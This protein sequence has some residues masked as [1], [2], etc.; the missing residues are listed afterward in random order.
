MME[1]EYRK[2]CVA[3]SQRGGLYPGMDIPEFYAMARELFTPQEAALAA[4]LPSKPSPAAVIARETGRDEKEAADLLETMA[5]KGL[6]SSFRK[7]GVRYYMGAPFVPGIFEFQFMR[8]TRTERDRKLAQLIHAYKEA[9]ARKKG[10]VEIKFPGN[11]VIP[12]GETIRP[13]SKVHTY[14]Q[15]S[16]Y[17]DKYEPI[18]VATCFC[19]HEAKL[20]NEKDSCGKPDDVCMQF[21]TGAEF[22]I[23]RGLGRKV[24]KEEAK[25]T[26]KRAAQAGLVHT[27]LNT[28]EIDFICNCCSCHC[29]LFKRILSQPKP[30]RILNSGF[31][32][33]MDP[34]LCTGCQTCVEICPAKAWKEGEDAPQVDLD[35][36]VGCGVCALNCP[37]QAIRMEEKGD[38]QEPPL[39]RKAL[40]AALEL[41]G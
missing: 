31:R 14:N 13:G 39:D 15:V 29:L 10:A 33:R 19:R 25:E 24:S 20:L 40:R 5:D 3:M 7:D 8:G 21:G 27:S 41:K 9:V 12:I 32:P 36:C 4:A 17:I 23:E 28:Q 34:E 37:T 35:R 18:S 38:A 6:C 30:G 11:R 26:L 22:V 16:S 1:E 2:L